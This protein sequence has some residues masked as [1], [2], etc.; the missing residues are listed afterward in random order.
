MDTMKVTL[1][2]ELP[3][4]ERKLNACL[5]A[6]KIFKSLR[7]FQ[8]ELDFRIAKSEN[9]SLDELTFIAAKKYL[10]EI[11]IKNGIEKKS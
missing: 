10:E 9:H 1:E 5:K 2:F 6:M 11:L 4:Q 3:K 8:E 7:E